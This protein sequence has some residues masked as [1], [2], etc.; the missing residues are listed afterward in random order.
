MDQ[1]RFTVL[2]DK[3]ILFMF[4]ACLSISVSIFV[5]CSCLLI[6]VYCSFLFVAHFQNVFSRINVLK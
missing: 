4:V 6:N 5:D 2:V 1:Q 3:C